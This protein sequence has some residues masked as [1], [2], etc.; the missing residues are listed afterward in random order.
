MI[1]RPGGAAV[2]AASLLA[3]ACGET[4]PPPPP[5]A[6]APGP[7]AAPALPPPR[8]PEQVILPPISYAARQR[9][10]PFTPPP[11]PVAEAKGASAF[12][13]FKV[14][15]VIS[16]PTGLMALVE[17][18]DGLGFIL[19]PG[20]VLEDGRVTRITRDEVR[21]AVAAP[22]P[23]QDPVEVTLRFQTNEGGTVR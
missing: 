18:A 20:S 5:V 21:I 13:A 4:A 2:I 17:R 7:V 1:R 3:A 6:P 22:R 15:G 23:G 8:E 14:V 16:G 9:R 12:D 11:A 10:D 19:R